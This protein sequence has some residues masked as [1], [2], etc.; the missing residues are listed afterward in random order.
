M[1]RLERIQ[2]SGHMALL[3]VSETSALILEQK[4]AI[5]TSAYFM[6]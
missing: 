2:P 4:L 3:T 6:A 1:E 5:L